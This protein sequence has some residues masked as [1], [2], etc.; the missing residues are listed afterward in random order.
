MNWHIAAQRL[1]EEAK[2]LRERAQSAFPND[3][4]V[5]KEM[6]TRAAIFEGLARAIHA[7]ASAS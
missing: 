3:I 5:Q 4:E 1:E 7:G 2:V 6:R